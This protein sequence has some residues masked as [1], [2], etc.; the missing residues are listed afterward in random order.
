MHQ[1]VIFIISLLFCLQKLVE[2]IGIFLLQFTINTHVSCSSF[3]RVFLLKY[4]LDVIYHKSIL[5]YLDACRRIFL[6]ETR[7]IIIELN[8]FCLTAIVKK[9]SIKPLPLPVLPDPS[10]KSL[11]R[12][13]AMTASAMVL[14]ETLLPVLF[15]EAEV[16]ALAPDLFKIIW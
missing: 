9:I 12:K 14:I 15:A 13:V 11:K 7:R 4:R 16:A 5:S 8:C 2:N 6:R 10:H 3:E 1:L